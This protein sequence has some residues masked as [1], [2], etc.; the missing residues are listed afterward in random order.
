[1][2]PLQGSEDLIVSDPGAALR[3]PLAI[4]SRA[5]GASTGK[6]GDMAETLPQRISSNDVA[7]RVNMNSPH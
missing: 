2:S 1:M 6:G 3:L 7:M 4:T 5:F